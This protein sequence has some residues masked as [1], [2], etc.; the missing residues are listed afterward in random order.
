MTTY[1]YQRPGSIESTKPKEKRSV[2][3]IGVRVAERFWNGPGRQTMTTCTTVT[4]ML[5]ALG[6]VTVL[7]E[8]GG[9]PGWL[10]VIIVFANLI[11]TIGVAMLSWKFFGWE[12]RKPE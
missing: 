3:N 1:K 4:I 7:L 5:A 8:Q 9:V 6:G 11:G 10:L 12:Y 2:L